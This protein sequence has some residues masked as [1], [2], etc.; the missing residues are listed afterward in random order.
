MKVR[1]TRIHKISDGEAVEAEI[2]AG[3]K[4]CMCIKIGLVFLVIRTVIIGG[5]KNSEM[6]HI[7]S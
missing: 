4:V 3:F 2:W 5:I 6:E 7:F 1:Y